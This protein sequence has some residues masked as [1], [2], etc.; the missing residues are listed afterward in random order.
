MSR[1]SGQIQGFC[2]RFQGFRGLQGF[3]AELKVFQIGF[4]DSRSRIPGILEI[5][6]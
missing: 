4:Q 6:V 2:G 1:F 5:L 3:Y